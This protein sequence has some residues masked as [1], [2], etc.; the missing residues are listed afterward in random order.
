MALPTEEDDAADDA[1]LG[2]SALVIHGE[3][4]DDEQVQE[5][6]RRVISQLE[7]DTLRTKKEKKGSMT[8]MLS[9]PQ[10]IGG[11]QPKLKKGYSD[12]HDEGQAGLED[13]NN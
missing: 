8:R 9:I 2:S 12:L 1:Y 11:K 5:S 7:H 3:D 13:D 10:M 4:D 6:Q